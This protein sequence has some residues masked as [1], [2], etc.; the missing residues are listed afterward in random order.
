MKLRWDEEPSPVKPRLA[1]HDDRGVEE[2]PN[3]QERYAVQF[4]ERIRGGRGCP[5]APRP[6]GS[7][8]RETAAGS[9]TAGMALP[10]C[11][12]AQ[13]PASQQLA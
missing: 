8:A 9:R 10:Q 1:R 6:Y 12:V 4:P 5:V 7:G 11:A 13:S 3:R 2:H